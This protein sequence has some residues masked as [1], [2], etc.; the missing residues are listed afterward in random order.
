MSTARSFFDDNNTFKFT[1]LQ[2]KH[3]HSL[4]KSHSL[5][6]TLA[7][8]GLNSDLSLRGLFKLHDN[9]L[10]YYNVKNRLIHFVVNSFLG[11]LSHHSSSCVG[12]FFFKTN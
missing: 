7:C 5:E 8:K 11:S 4:T 10:A 3:I 12:S 2:P 1:P 9:I 6:A